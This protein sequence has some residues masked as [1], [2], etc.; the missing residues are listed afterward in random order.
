M[1]SNGEN[2]RG[3]ARG[4]KIKNKIKEEASNNC[5]QSKKQTQA[6]IKGSCRV[7]PAA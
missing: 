7:V 4:V 6:N 5:D 3:E 2:A 1:E